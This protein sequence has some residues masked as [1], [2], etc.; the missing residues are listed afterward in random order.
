MN[1]AARQM[2]EKPPMTFLIFD[3]L[4]FD[5]QYDYFVRI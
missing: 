3:E 5:F 1:D 4:G 2:V